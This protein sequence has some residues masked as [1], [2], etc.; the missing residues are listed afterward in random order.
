MNVHG[1]LSNKVNF[2]LIYLYN[3]TYN[4]LLPK[5]YKFLYITEIRMLETPAIQK[6]VSPRVA[7]SSYFP[8]DYS[9]MYKVILLAAIQI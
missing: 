1:T 7:S 4:E 3:N 2:T 9:L 8:T 6:T 5:L